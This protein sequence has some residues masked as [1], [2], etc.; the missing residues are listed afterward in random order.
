[1]QR[2]SDAAALTLCIQSRGD[3][4]CVRVGLN[5]AGEQRIQLGDP[6]EIFPRELPTGQRAG[7]HQSLELGDSRLDDG[8]IISQEDR[9][10]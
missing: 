1:M 3:G 10:R 2:T 6:F 4:E 7:L 8:P 9:R 5:Y